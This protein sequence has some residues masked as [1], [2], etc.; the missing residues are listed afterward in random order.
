MDVGD[1]TVYIQI[2]ICKA[3]LRHPNIYA[4]AAKDEDPASRLAFKVRF[5]DSCGSEVSYYETNNNITPIF[6]ANAFVDILAD[7]KP[8]EVIART[9]RRYLNI[10]KGCAPPGL[11]EFEGGK[12]TSPTT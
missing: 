7:E 10:H 1:G 8:D 12:Y 2:E 4:T 6:R 11:E 3:G 5:K 9:A